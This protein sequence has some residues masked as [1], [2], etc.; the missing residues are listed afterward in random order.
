M[1]PGGEDSMIWARREVIVTV[2]K[3]NTID[4]GGSEESSTPVCQTDS[5]EL[6]ATVTL[7]TSMS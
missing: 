7:P 3:M 1:S 2:E 6:Y 4:E 5:L